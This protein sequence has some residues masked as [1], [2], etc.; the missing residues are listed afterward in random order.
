MGARGDSRQQALAP[1]LVLRSFFPGSAGWFTERGGAAGGGAAAGGGGGG[2]GGRGAGGGRYTGERC[3]QPPRRMIANKS[4]SLPPE[5]E[6]AADPGPW[7]GGGGGPPGLAQ[8]WRLSCI[9]IPSLTFSLQPSH[10]RIPLTFSPSHH[11]LLLLRFPLELL[12]HLH[13]P[14]LPPGS[15]L[16]PA[17]SL[18]APVRASSLPA[19]A[20][21]PGLPWSQPPAPSTRAPWPCIPERPACR[22]LLPC[23]HLLPPGPGRRGAAVPHRRP[24]GTSEAGPPAP[25]PPCPLLLTFPPCRFPSARPQT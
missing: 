10:L 7:D 17:S 16:H 2:G 5:L 9:T 18:S 25:W 12:P 23:W 3:S 19:R 14:P 22:L 4:R 13:P 24:P 8:P 11:R 20:S 15:H 6:P 21:I 1:W